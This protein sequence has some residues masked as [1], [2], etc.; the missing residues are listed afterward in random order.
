MKARRGGP[1][2]RTDWEASARMPR[3]SVGRPAAGRRSGGGRPVANIAAIIAAFA[4]A[5]CATAAAAATPPPRSHTRPFH[6]ALPLRLVRDVRLPGRATRFDYESFDPRTGLLF[7]SHLGDSEVLRFNTRTQR[8][9]GAVAGVSR[10][11][12]VLAV[13]ALGRVYAS[14]T[15]FNQVF[16]INERTLRILA[17]IPGGV[18]P[19]GMAYVPGRHRLFVSDELGGTDTVIDTRSERRVATIQLGGQAGNSQ[20]DRGSGR[21][22]VDVQTENRLKAIN[23][24]T[25][26]IVASYPLPGCQHDHGLLIDSRARLAFVACDH[27]ARLLTFDLRTHRVLASHRLGKYPDV[28]KFDRG[29]Q[30]LYVAAE[31]GVVSVFALRGRQLHLLGRAHLAYEAHSVAVDSQHRVYFPLQDIDGHPL[32]RIMR[33]VAR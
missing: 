20:Y 4:L 30:R 9:Q 8:L 28:L 25:D 24:A 3:R 21:V 23:P 18:Y 31:S 5:A 33:P 26:R 10:V 6:K 7:I 15:G 1:A 17:R 11:H 2:V 16:A 32:L 22:Y 19:D 13:P 29:L 27:N 12:G 14:A